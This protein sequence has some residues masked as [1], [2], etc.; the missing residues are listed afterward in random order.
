MKVA[1]FTVR[2]SMDQSIRWKRAAEAEGF[3]S[4]GAWISGAV[5]VYLK[6]RARAGR[7]LPLA[8]RYG[9][10][11]VALEGGEIE[12]RGMVSPPFAYFQ[13]NGQGP[14]RNMPRTL[15]HMPRRQVI[16]T[17]RSARQ[18][19]ELGAE[20]A[21]A[22]ARDEASAAGIIQRHQRESA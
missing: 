1:A 18:C 15:V 3:R 16:A 21:P 7:P 13:G 5:D 9:R 20:L 12:V 22:Y 14:N 4:V 19:R 8:W 10:F 6:A 11:L 17:L 2:A